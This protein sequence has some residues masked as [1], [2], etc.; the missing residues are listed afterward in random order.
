MKSILLLLLFL[1]IN[2][3]ASVGETETQAE[4]EIPQAEVEILLSAAEKGDAD[5]KFQLGRLYYRGQGIA[6][7]HRKALEMITAA[8]E[9]GH[10]E[11]VSTMGYLYSKG[12]MVPQDDAKAVEWFRKGA[13][14][15][16]LKSQLNLG[17]MLR[18]SKTLEHSPEESLEWITKA[19]DSGL[20]EARAVLG[21]LLFTGDRY[22]SPDYPR[23]FQYLLQPAEEGD[24]I[25]QNMVGVCYRDGRGVSQDLKAAEEWFRKSALQNHLKAQSN[26]ALVMGVESPQSE[27]REEALTWLLIASEQAEPTATKTLSELTPTFSSVLLSQARKEAAKFLTIQRAGGSTGEKASEA[28]AGSPGEG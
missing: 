15:G 21:R 8:A 28:Q 6:E 7:D 13:E 9:A 18:Q 12:E 24:P 5:A 22:L 1:L 25:C 19:A 2:P 23:A 17:L 4:V 3:L 27:H 10:P 26:L 11:A 20:L 14:K 16:S